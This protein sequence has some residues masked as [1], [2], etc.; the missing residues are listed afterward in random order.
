[1]VGCSVRCGDCSIGLAAIG[2]GGTDGT[3]AV[4]IGAS[5]ALG[6]RLGRLV[7]AS[8]SDVLLRGSLRRPS[9]QSK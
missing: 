7:W 3:G 6:G 9:A 1:V 4:I 2:A 8:A 5:P